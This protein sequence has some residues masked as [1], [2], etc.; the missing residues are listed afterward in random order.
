V[1]LAVLSAGG[2]SN[3]IYP[4]GCASQVHYLCD[5]SST[6][7]LFCGRRRRTTHKALEVRD[8]LPR[9]GKI[10]VF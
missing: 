3:G 1:D 5:D 2:V 4:T 10:V 6:S 8:Q 9:R 7:V